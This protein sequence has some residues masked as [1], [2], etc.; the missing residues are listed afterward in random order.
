MTDKESPSSAAPEQSTSTSGDLVQY[1]APDFGVIPAELM[2]DQRVS[3]NA[4]LLGCL[5]WSY[6]NKDTGEAFPKQE[7]LAGRIGVSVR[8]IQKWMAE[9]REHGW[10]QSQHRISVDTSYHGNPGALIHTLYW[11]A[12]KGK[13]EQPDVSYTN[14][15]SPTTRTPTA[16]EHTNRTDQKNISGDRPPEI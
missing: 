3:R 16:Q 9:L 13:H 6:R 8:S 1:H 4:R 10:M 11:S 5:L 7:T 15:R 14:S 2:C 12:N